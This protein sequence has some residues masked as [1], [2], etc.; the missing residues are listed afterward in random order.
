MLTSSDIATCSNIQC[1]KQLLY[2]VYIDPCIYFTVYIYSKSHIAD[3]AWD[4]FY[5]AFEVYACEAWEI[6]LRFVSHP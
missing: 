3:D 1:M 5:Y 2:T 4:N 6:M